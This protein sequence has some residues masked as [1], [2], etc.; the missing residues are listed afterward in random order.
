MSKILNSKCKLCRR[1]GEKLFLKGDRCLS[2]KCAVI[3]KPYAP[4]IHGKDRSGRKTSSEYS[5]Q[6]SQKQKIKRIY[7]ISEKQIFKHLEEARK[8]KGLLGDNLIGRL[9][10]RMDNVVYKLQLA[11]TRSLARQLVSHSHFSINERSCNIPSRWLKIGDKISVKKSKG[12][13][14]YFKNLK[15]ILKKKS[16]IPQWLNFDVENM[17]GKIVAKPTR[18]D[19]G[20]MLDT[21]SLI[22]FYSR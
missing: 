12:E 17:E 13:K 9:E 3:K 1:A 6:L 4:G 11:S 7:G 15:L 22:E 21:Q 18:D 16:D 14:N 20:M 10:M 19:A 5:R 8:Q 2:A